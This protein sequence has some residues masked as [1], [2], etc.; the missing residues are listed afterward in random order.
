[1]KTD[2]LAQIAVEILAGRG[3]VRKI[4]TDNRNKLLNIVNSAWN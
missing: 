2:G 4:E 3:S 1:M